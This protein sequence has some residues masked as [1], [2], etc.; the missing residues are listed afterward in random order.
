MATNAINCGQIHARRWWMLT[1]MSRI[2]PRLG[3]GKMAQI[4]VQVFKEI[5][6]N[7]RLPKIKEQLK[8]AS[9]IVGQET[10]VERLEKVLR[11]VKANVDNSGEDPKIK[12]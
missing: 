2:S 1:A 8:V 3:W 10:D 7:S 6:G 9:R 5:T 4:S 12:K 11:N